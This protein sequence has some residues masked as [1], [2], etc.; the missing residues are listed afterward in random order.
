MTGKEKGA[1]VFLR[2]P[3]FF[4]VSPVGIEPTTY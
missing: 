4:L 2:N 3:L 1:T